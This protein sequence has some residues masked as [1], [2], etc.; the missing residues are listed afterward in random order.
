MSQKWK[1][2]DIKEGKLERKNPSCPR[3]GL[4]VFMAEHK[5]RHSC[6]SCGYTDWKKR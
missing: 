1:I 6:G 3:C 2:Y 5:D 4:G